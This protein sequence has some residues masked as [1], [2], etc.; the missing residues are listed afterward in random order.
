MSKKQ[1]IGLIAAALAFVFVGVAS[2]VTHSVFNADKEASSVESTMA[3]VANSNK[4][5]LPDNDFIGVV[6]VEGT[7]MNTSSSNSLFSSDDTYNH[8]KTLEYIDNM[9]KSSTN[10][11]ILLYVNSPGGGVYESD[12]L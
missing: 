12:E 11:G 3:S 10:K 8:K 9:T 2:A 7:I 5:E 4:V 1:I 6:K